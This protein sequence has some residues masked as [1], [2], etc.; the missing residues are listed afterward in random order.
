M[1]FSRRASPWPLRIGLA[2]VL[3]AS[4]AALQRHRAGARGA[5]TATNVAPSSEPSSAISTRDEMLARCDVLVIGGT[6]SGA[7]AAIA[8][9]RH[10]ARVILIEEHDHLGGDIVYAMLNMFDVPMKVHNKSPV[11]TGIF[12]EFFK[13][14]GIAFD[15]N[16]ARRLFEEKVAAEPNIRVLCHTRIA[17]VTFD[18]SAK[19]PTVTGATVEDI[20]HPELRAQITCDAVVDATNNADF[21]AL[22]GAHFYLGRGNS[23]IDQKMQAAGLLFSLAGTDWH[24]MKRYVR[25]VRVVRESEPIGHEYASDAAPS[26]PEKPGVKSDKK[27]DASVTLHLGG[28]DG[29]YLWER[30][31]VVKNYRPH[32]ADVIV[33]SLN[34]GLQSDGSIVFNT[35]NVVNVNGLDAASREAARRQAIDELE[36][37]I[38]YL[39]GAMP[40]LEKARL[41]RVAPELY[42]RETRHLQGFYTISVADIRAGAQFF[43]RVALACYPIDLHPYQKGDFNRFGPRRYFYTLPLRSL[44][45]RAVDGV[46][47][48]SRCLSA[49]YDA[50]GSARVVPITMAAG[51]AA[52][53]AAWWCAKEKTTPHAILKNPAAITEIQNVLRESGADIGDRIKGFATEKSIGQKPKHLPAL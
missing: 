36:Y 32:G 37:F 27:S 11:A 20:L 48:A 16:A 9:A 40:G 1:R 53:V 52:G 7:A 35:L 10:G 25:G 28:M 34:C 45:P 2:V 47:V 30:G 26:V 15:I 42:I 5:S 33:L 49:T 46:L 41:M 31:D 4:V 51:E 50:A 6:P 13:P 8:A 17:Q 12:G 3:I 29:K 14:L 24:R 19:G 44:V 38:P 43:D 21:A 23:G 39:R 18:D 22:S